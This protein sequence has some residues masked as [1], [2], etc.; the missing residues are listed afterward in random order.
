MTARNDIV[1]KMKLPYVKS[2]FT[3]LFTKAQSLTKCWPLN[4]ISAQQS[5]DTQMPAKRG[6]MA[7]WDRWVVSSLF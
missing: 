3:Q 6:D 7:S 4:L 1:S 2:H 5:P